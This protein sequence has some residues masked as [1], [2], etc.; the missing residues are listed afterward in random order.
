MLA[1][2]DPSTIQAQLDQADANLA[3]AQASAAEASANTTAQAAGATAAQTAIP[4]A[5]AALTVAQQQLTRDSTLLK[6]G[7]VAQ[8]T[9]QTDQSTVAQDEAAVS[10]SASRLHAIEARKRKRRARVRQRLQRSAQAAAATVRQDSVNLNNTVITSPVTGTVVARDVSIGQTVAASLQTPT[11]FLIA[12][13]LSKME[14]DI[15]VGEPDIG[16]VKAGNG[17]NFTVLA[18]PNQI[19]NGTVTQVRI[20]P[21]TV[22]N[23]VTYDVVVDV[24]NSSGKLLPGMTAERHDQRCK[25]TECAGGSAQCDPHQGLR[26]KCDEPLGW[27]GKYI[28]RRNTGRKRNDHR[29]TRKQTPACAGASWSRHRNASRSHANRWCNAASRRQ[30]GHRIQQRRAQR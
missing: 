27:R 19:F 14:V 18:Y 30:S 5:Q 7:Y 26:D 15:N 29:A 1:R 3:Q 28:G 16:G 24:N 11:L 9:V 6:Q 2:I 20:N 10:A 8:E 17:V 21:T 4:K 13:D 25:R 12:Q 23:V 22:N